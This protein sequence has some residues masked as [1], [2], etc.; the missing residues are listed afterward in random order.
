MEHDQILRM[1]RKVFEV[2]VKSILRGLLTENG[3][4]DGRNLF[5]TKDELLVVFRDQ[6]RFEIDAVV[7]SARQKGSFQQTMDI[8]SDN[9]SS[10][11]VPVHRGISTIMR[12]LRA[13]VQ[14]IASMEVATATASAASTSAVVSVSQGI[15]QYS[16]N[17]GGSR[18]RE[19][20]DAEELPHGKKA[21]SDDKR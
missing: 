2:D 5:P 21:R 20:S 9:I 16:N 8:T 13:D 4:Y 19:E 1:G 14:N 11:S 6:F 18:E 12:A 7:G 10:R 15:T 3:V 17:S